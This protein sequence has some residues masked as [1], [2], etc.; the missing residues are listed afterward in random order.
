MMSAN[1]K[2]YFQSLPSLFLMDLEVG[3][4][5]DLLLRLPQ[6]MAAAPLWKFDLPPFSN[7][8]AFNWKNGSWSQVT[9]QY[10]D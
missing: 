10:I 3:I 8:E 7:I 2:K 5:Q 4:T 6:K 9:A 1:Y